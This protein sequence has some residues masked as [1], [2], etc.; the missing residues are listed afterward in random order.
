MTNEA[1][2]NL[3]AH[4]INECRDVMNARSAIYTG[5]ED[6]LAGFKEI[7]ADTGLSPQMVCLVL[8]S[9]HR[10]ALTSMLRK[11]QTPSLDRLAEWMTD[12]HNY[13]Y[14]LEA[15]CSESVFSHAFD[16]VMKNETQK[17][18]KAI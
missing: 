16:K 17:S 8:M 10:V 9:K 3:I 14:L 12:L 6:R 5:D 7:A 15:L 11:G 1:F 2:Q 13:Y 4:R 18:K